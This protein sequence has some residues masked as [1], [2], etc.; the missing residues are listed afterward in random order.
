MGE[1][2]DEDVR[3]L[4]ARL[5]DLAR[6]GETE[7]LARYVDEGVPVDLAN[8]RGDTLLMLAAY[9]GHAAAVRAL[10]KRGARPDLQN[11]HGQTPL[12]GA[13]FKGDA[14]VAQVLLEYG[15]A[16]DGPCA[17][18]RTPLMYA[19]MFDRVEVVQLLLQRGADR[20]YRDPG[21]A[22]ARDLAVTMGAVR[23]AE[24]LRSLEE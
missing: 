3:A 14:T 24:R 5:F 22:S 1:H 19:A 12:A 23:V 11:A 4:A 8:E 18:G 15:A 17:D 16:V 2:V 6:G 21:G 7:Q 10:L 13:A 20:R 9:N